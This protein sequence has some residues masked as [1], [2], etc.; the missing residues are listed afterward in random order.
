MKAIPAVRSRG[1]L[2]LSHNKRNAS[3]TVR[4]N[5]AQ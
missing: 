1:G 5:E 4:W 3:I 2:D